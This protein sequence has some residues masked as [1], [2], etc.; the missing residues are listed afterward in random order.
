[1]EFIPIRKVISNAELPTLKKVVIEKFNSSYIVPIAIE[2]DANKGCFIKRLQLYLQFWV[3]FFL[4]RAW[5][6]VSRCALIFSKSYSVI[7]HGQL[8]EGLMV[9]SICGAPEL[10]ATVASGEQPTDEKVPPITE[11]LYP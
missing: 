1:L 3:T 8:L 10:E 6:Y 11:T 2:I 4:N 5:I 9:T 7:F